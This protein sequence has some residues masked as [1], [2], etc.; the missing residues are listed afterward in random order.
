MK[1]S[2]AEKF[3]FICSPFRP[4]S[5]GAESRAQE[6]KENIALAHL[7]CALA[8][9]LGHIPVAP[10]LYFPQFLDDAKDKERNLGIKMGM[11]WLKGCEELWIIGDRITEGMAVEIAMAIE[12]GIPI[13]V[14]PIDGR[15][16]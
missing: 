10:H 11:E 7:A 9:S 1:E 8:V 15:N 14:K 16:S 4:V 2:L 12:M 13:K 6:F 3:V 5:R